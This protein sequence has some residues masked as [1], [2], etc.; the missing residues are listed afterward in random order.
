MCLLIASAA[1]LL[2]GCRAPEGPRSFTFPA[3]DYPA[4]LD[5]TREKLRAAGYTL[6]RVDAVRGEVLT[7]PKT[8]AGFTTPIEPEYNTLGSAWQDTLNNQPRTVR[9]RFRDAASIERG[10]A[11]PPTATGEIHAE[12]E[13]VI[14]RLSRP[15]WRLETETISE[16]SMSRDP[17]LIERGVTPNM[18]V[19]LRR[20]DSFSAELAA[21]VRRRLAKSAPAAQAES[22]HA[23]SAQAESR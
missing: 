1:A 14:Y 22:A 6:E 11:R 9:V 3:S 5:A 2:T 15:G 19:P 18:L 20:D 4:V 10:D 12:V 13:S 23:E 8:S 7:T 21:K 16:S 17:L